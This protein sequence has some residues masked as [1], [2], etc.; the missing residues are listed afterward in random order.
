MIRRRTNALAGRSSRRAASDMSGFVATEFVIGIAFLLLPVTLLVSAFPTWSERKEMAIV[1]AREAA[2]AYVL[3]GDPAAAQRVVDEIETN[4]SLEDDSL[5]LELSGDPRVRGGE[6]T[7]IVHIG[8]PATIIPI[9]DANA[10][11]FTF[12]D[13][14]TEIV[15]QYRSLP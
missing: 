15:D 1:A 6:V 12:T 11:A 14:H 8:V 4:Y 5:T 3:T 2:R 13:S 7:A 9:L 10:D